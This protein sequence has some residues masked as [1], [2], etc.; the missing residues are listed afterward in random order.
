MKKDITIIDKINYLILVLFL[1]FVLSIG[2][3][4]WQP[5]NKSLFQIFNFSQNAGWF[6]L[7]TRVIYY[8]I[9]F[10]SM[11]LIGIGF[12]AGKSLRGTKKYKSET[13]KFCIAFFCTRIAF[14]IIKYFVSQIIMSVVISVIICFDIIESLFDIAVLFFAFHFMSKRKTK[15]EKKSVCNGAVLTMTVIIL[16]AVGYV[17]V[18]N[19]N[20]YDNRDLFC[21][22]LY[23]LNMLRDIAVSFSAVITACGLFS[24]NTV[25]RQSGYK[26]FTVFFT[27]LWAILLI[28][29][30][31]IA[32]KALII[33]Q[34]VLYSVTTCESES[35][36][37]ESITAHRAKGYD[38]LFSNPD[39][40]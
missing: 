32:T 2:Y 19:S 18:V 8:I 11:I 33:P 28:G 25:Q 26:K 20:Y 34:S 36:E 4:V 5:Y 30:I 21:M 17:K 16:L 27:R 39:D 22:R 23:E 29:S 15:I 9:Y 24:F 1:F 14:D 31:I 38:D 7:L 10:V 12:F 13:I 6:D 35:G 3:F 40:F 37:T